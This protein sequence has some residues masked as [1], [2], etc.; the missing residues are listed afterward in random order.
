MIFLHHPYSD[1]PSFVQ[2]NEILDAIPKSKKNK[3]CLIHSLE[4]QKPRTSTGNW[5]DIW[6]ALSQECREELVRLEQ[7]G[8]V[9]TVEAYLRKHRFCAECKSKVMRAYHLLVGEEDCSKE[10]GYCPAVY[11]GL[12][13]CSGMT[14][15][16]LG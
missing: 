4:T 5:M 9:D 10:K 13:S 15:C 1:Y 3:R 11:E 7:D 14:D 16:I 8:L 12:R 6:E 2:C